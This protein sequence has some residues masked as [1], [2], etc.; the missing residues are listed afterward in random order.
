MRVHAQMNAVRREDRRSFEQLQ[1]QYKACVDAWREDQAE[2]MNDSAQLAQQRR[3]WVPTVHRWMLDNGRQAFPDPKDS[4]TMLQ[5]IKE[6]DDFYHDEVVVFRNKVCLRARWLRCTRS[7]CLGA[8]ASV[9]TVPCVRCVLLL[10]RSL[11]FVHVDSL[12]RLLTTPAT[13]HASNQP[14]EQPTT[15][16]TN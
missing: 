13:N 6:A 9:R 4:F 14:P 3:P 1:V 12:G 11:Q 15:R 16:A 10:A 5:A 8:Y 7:P 2:L